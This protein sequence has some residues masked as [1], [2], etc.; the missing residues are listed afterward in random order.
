MDKDKIVLMRYNGDCEVAVIASILGIS[1][2]KASNAIGWKEM[3]FGIHDPLFGNPYNLYL[4]LLRL[5]YWKRNINWIDLQEQGTVCVLLHFPS[6]P[7]LKQHW[8]IRDKI[9]ELGN[10]M[11]YF[12]MSKDYTIITNYNMKRLFLAGYPNCAFSVY[13]CNV[14]KKILEYI[15]LKWFNYWCKNK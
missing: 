10:H 1:Y 15:K 7:N 2:N 4:S 3:P 5:G 13:K 6:D 12:G 8:V 11:C 14:F 9:D